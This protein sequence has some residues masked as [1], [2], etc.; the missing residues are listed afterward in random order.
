[1]Y[2]GSW[3]IGKTTVFNS[4]G[5]LFNLSVAEIKGASLLSGSNFRF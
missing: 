5:Y 2:R 3:L 1:M 4:H